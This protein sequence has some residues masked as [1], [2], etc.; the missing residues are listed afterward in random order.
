MLGARTK[1]TTL[2]MWLQF[3]NDPYSEAVTQYAK[4]IPAIAEA[5]DVFIKVNSDPIAREEWR[6]REKSIYD[7]ASALAGGREEERL[8]AEQKR[9]EEKHQI[10]RNALAQGISIEQVVIITGLSRAEV[11]ALESIKD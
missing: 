9:Q 3:I 5:R 11:E 10:A 2:E 4:E 6:L 1:N 8:I 7:E